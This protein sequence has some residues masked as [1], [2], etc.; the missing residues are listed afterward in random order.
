M[1][2]SWHTPESLYAEVGLCALA[3]IIFGYRAFGGTNDWLRTHGIILVTYYA[4]GSVV[5][6]EIEGWPLIDSSYFLTVTITTVGYG[7]LTPTTDVGKMFTVVYALVGV[8]FVFAALT[9]LVTA[10]GFIKEGVLAPFKP[11]DLEPNDDE[12][13]GLEE[14]RAR[15]NWTYKYIAAV[16]GPLIIFV[17]GL[18]IGFTVMDLGLVD[19]IYWSMITM[20]TIGY[21]DIA[22]TTFYG[23]IVLCLYL[24]TA[25][26]ALAEAISELGVLSTAKDLM[27]TNFAEQAD[28]LLLGEAGGT[29]PNPEETLTEAE[30][31]ISVLKDKEIVDDMTVKTIRQQF[32]HIVRHD[33]WSADRSNL[34]LDDKVVFLEM[35]AQGRIAQSGKGKPT[36]DSAGHAIEHVD[37]TKPDE[38]FSEWKATYWLPR[39]F[40]GH[41]HGEQVRMHHPA[42]A[43]PPSAAPTKTLV[44][45]ETGE[46]KQ[47]QRMPE[48]RGGSSMPSANG[49][50]ARGGAYFSDGAPMANGEYVWMPHEQARRH[51]TKGNDK[52]LGLWFLLALFLC[53]FVWKILPGVITHHMYGPATVDDSSRRALAQAGLAGLRI[54]DTITGEALNKVAHILRSR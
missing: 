35:R 21:G 52:D 39:V 6:D 54:G 19:G 22:A 45:T 9:P 20:T 24:P 15:G 30:F 2:L 37:L 26:A 31:L 13:L 7:D 16:M 14:L 32:A 10:L 8:I 27:E 40:D 47:F 5:Y 28:T 48:S 44:D 51:R 12:E 3:L 43:K 42:A 18:A 41:S 36:K 4:L 29:H 33:T 23:K 1:V 25:V 53:Y 34:V 49:T 17:A 50:P 11:T 46:R 38:G